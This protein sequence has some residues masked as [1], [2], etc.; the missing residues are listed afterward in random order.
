MAARAS[1][2]LVM[3]QILTRTMTTTRPRRSDEKSGKG[4]AGI[5]RKHEMRADEE[6]IEARGTKLHEVVV[7]AQAGFAD[8]DAAVGNAADQFE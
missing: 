3:P 7:G 2:A 8:G 6:G 1:A 5:G 4:R